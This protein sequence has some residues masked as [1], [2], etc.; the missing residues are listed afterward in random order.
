MLVARYAG[1]S[2]IGHEGGFGEY[3]LERDVVDPVLQIGAQGKIDLSRPYVYQTGSGFK[4][5]PPE[6]WNLGWG[7]QP[8]NPLT[9]HGK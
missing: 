2:L 1:R 4:N 3:L 8:R 7:L 9:I 6:N 5:I